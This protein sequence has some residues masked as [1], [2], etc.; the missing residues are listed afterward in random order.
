VRIRLNAFA[1]TFRK[2]HRVRLSLSTSYWPL[3]WPSPEP[4]RLVVDTE[5]S[6]LHLPVR[7]P[8]P[9]DDAVKFDPPVGAR[10]GKTEILAFPEQDW[11]IRTS[12]G[13]RVTVQEVTDDGGRE[14]YED[15]DLTVGEKMISRF[16]HGYEDHDSLSGETVT[17]RTFQRGDWSVRTT[18][19]TVLT[20][21]PTHFQVRAELD[22]Y[23]GVTRVFSENWIEEIERHL[24]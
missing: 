14:R 19:R 21:T 12:L 1:Q 3:A 15:I 2:G 4:A 24:V 18:T 9:E 5:H 20:A 7:R 8:R 23:E 11:V 22:A 10:P 16:I 13:N 17:E 6:Q